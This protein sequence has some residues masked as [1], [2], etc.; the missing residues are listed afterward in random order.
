M[1]TDTGNT[2]AEPVVAA[3]DAPDNENNKNDRRDGL[4]T[5]NQFHDGM[6]LHIL[7]M[8]D[9]ESLCNFALASRACYILH[10]DMELWR[11]IAVNRYA[12][13]TQFKRDWKQ[14][15]LLPNDFSQPLPQE[16]LL[17]TFLDP[18]S[19]RHVTG[20]YATLIHR[21]YY[22]SQRNLKGW[23]LLDKEG[24]PRVHAAQLS[25]D[26]FNKNFE[27]KHLP[28]VIC[29]GTKTWAWNNWDF[30]AFKSQY[31]DKL[32]KMS[33]Y[34]VRTRKRVRMKFS[35]YMK[36]MEEQRDHDPLYLF[37][38]GFVKRHPEMRSMYE[39]P[40][41]FQDDLLNYLDD[42][43]R[44]VHRWILIGPRRS[45]SKFH[46]DPI[47]SSAWNALVYGKKRWA[48][49]P[50]G[51]APLGT[52]P[53]WRDEEFESDVESLQWYLEVYPHLKDEDKPLEF[54]QHPGD[55]VFVPG[56]WWHA[57]LNITDT[58][59]VTQ[60]F[61]SPSLLPAAWGEMVNTAESNLFYRHMMRFLRSQIMTYRPELAAVVAKG[62][63]VLGFDLPTPAQAWGGVPTT[64][65]P[66]HSASSYPTTT[67]TA[68]YVEGGF[69]RVVT[70][71][72]TSIPLA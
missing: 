37:D 32:F 24:V 11:V 56:G 28:V 21:R 29:G 65:P 67:T 3:S 53:V 31:G 9:A 62:A 45:G 33:Q 26:E 36:Y 71:T 22:R 25:V 60:N 40:P 47:G 4:G 7:S 15:A 10:T 13:N 57:V 1:E 23:D 59:S 52:K 2:A 17:D 5:L 6:I 39:V 12:D 54:I 20:F 68:T 51:V 64:A 16:T 61:I 27:Q 55:I 70:T 18:S 66:D 8:L 30:E 35:N 43:I 69:L 48:L 44:P 14:T 72:T 49:Y 38:K 50:P 46:V 41:Y 63:D 58:V 34:H 42:D 19:P